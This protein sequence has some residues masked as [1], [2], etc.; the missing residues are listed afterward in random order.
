MF[1]SYDGA[2]YG[3]VNDAGRRLQ[4]AGSPVSDLL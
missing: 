4:A 1:E 3:E 2:M